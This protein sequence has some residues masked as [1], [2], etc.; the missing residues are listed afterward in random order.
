MAFLAFILPISVASVATAQIGGMGGIGRGGMGG[1]GG[2]RGG[3]MRGGRAG[4][5]DEAM[6][7]PPASELQKFNP[8]QF[9][10]DKRKDLKLTDLQMD[11]LKALR[12][13]IFERNGDLMAR[14]DS[15]Q[16]DYTPPRFDG[17]RDRQGSDSTIQVALRKARDLRELADSLIARRA[18]DVSDVLAVMQD[19]D[20]RHKAA[21]LLQ[22]QDVEMLDK[23]PRAGNMRRRG[24]H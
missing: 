18:I 13:R 7:F 10:M 5:M 19:D 22:K 1:M 2:R 6:K 20:Q 23:L 24:M 11:T 3:G 12:Q 15:I 8:A 21:G 9:L 14:Y 17:S 4:N 16:R